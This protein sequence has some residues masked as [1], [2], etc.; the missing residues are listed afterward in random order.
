MK[1]LLDTHTLLWLIDRPEKLPKKVITFCEDMDNELFVSIASFWELSIKISLGKI[2][3][4]DQAL[5]QIK[6]WCNDNAVSILPIS[7][8]HCQKIQELPFHHRDPFDRLILAQATCNEL[9]VISIDE[10]FP[11][12]DVE[13]LWK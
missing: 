4:A 6:N 12:Y 2:E 13:I 3:L 10:H 5:E 11:A 9:I 1:A 7:V 8:N